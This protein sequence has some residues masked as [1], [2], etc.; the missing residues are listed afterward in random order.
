M[1]IIIS[2]CSNFCFCVL[3]FYVCTVIDSF[4]F[5][6]PERIT[7][8]SCVKEILRFTQDDRYAVDFSL[9]CYPDSMALPMC[10]PKSD[11]YHFFITALNTNHMCLHIV[12][13]TP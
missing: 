2:Y 5:S 4:C 9:T 13:N 8:Q 3:S 11:R 10:P 6:Q 7:Y 1:V 12:G